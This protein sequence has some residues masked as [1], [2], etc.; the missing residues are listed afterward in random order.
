MGWYKTHPRLKPDSGFEKFPKPI[1]SLIIIEHNHPNR[2]GAGWVTRIV[3]KTTITNAKL[4]WT[5]TNRFKKKK[6]ISTIDVSIKVVCQIG[7]LISNQFENNMWRSNQYVASKFW[8]M[9]SWNL[10][11]SSRFQEKSVSHQNFNFRYVQNWFDLDYCIFQIKNYNFRDC[12]SEWG[13]L[14]NTLVYVANENVL[15][16]ILRLWYKYF[17]LG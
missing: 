11:G 15:N 10:F 12:F 7:F 8:F 5:I 16:V 13:F 17:L 14:K 2:S 9:R 1:P 4:V 3:R 6:S